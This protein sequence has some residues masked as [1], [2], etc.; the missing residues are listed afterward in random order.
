M[1]RLMWRLLGRGS[2]DEPNRAGRRQFDAIN[3]KVAARVGVPKASRA[4][5]RDRAAAWLVRRAGR[6]HPALALLAGTMMLEG[7]TTLDL[8][9]DKIGE[10]TDDVFRKMGLTESREA[11]VALSK[12]VDRI[13]ADHKGD[14]G[15]IKWSEITDAEGKR[16]GKLN[17]LL[18]YATTRYEDLT[19]F[20]NIRKDAANAARH[21]GQPVTHLLHPGETKGGKPAQRPADPGAEW[22][23][24][25]AYQEFKEHRNLDVLKRAGEIEVRD[26]LYEALEAEFK[27]VLGTDSSLVDVGS[28]Y[29]PESVRVGRIVETLYQE[30][31]MGPLF[32]QL[33]TSQAAI[34]YMQETVNAEA[35]AEAAEGALT[36]EASIDWAETTEPIRKIAVSIP[37]T[38]ELLADEPAMRGIVNSRL[39]QFMGNRE[40]LQLIQGD[41]VAPNLEGILN[42]AGIGNVNWSVGT[43]TAQQLLEA[44]L[45]AF[46]TVFEAF[47]NPT[48]A[49]GAWDTW[50]Y[51]RLAKDQNDN[52]LL[53]PAAIEGVQR[54]WG[55]PFRT[56]QNFQDRATA[57][58]VPI[59]TGDFRGAATIFRRQGLTVQVT[60]SHSDEF[61]RGVLRIRMTTRLGL[62]KW[63]PSGFTTVSVIA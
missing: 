19:E 49:A 62:V 59:L 47:Q 6:R 35:A 63:R 41:G 27:A 34:P 53:G 5:I 20:D 26:P 55:R 58:N 2:A 50:E 52:Y 10:I 48:A 4:L 39:R 28:E 33:P 21:M 9:A 32:S 17:E 29:P 57:G 56:N 13:F 54:V 7:A 43:G 38:E 61:L 23:Q 36:A 14:D 18:D 46:G 40:D 37:V 1:L 31:N 44:I 45:S 16:L 25:D 42:T 30:H 24:S 60:D 3:R 51:L 11:V 15:E 22:L 12:E 8:E